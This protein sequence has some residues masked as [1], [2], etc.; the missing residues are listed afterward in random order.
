MG[1]TT[2][3]G[4]FLAGLFAALLIVVAVGV[5][6]R[7]SLGSALLYVTGPAW[8]TADGAM[9]A[10][11]GIQAEI[12]WMQQRLMGESPAARDLTN[13]H[14]MAAEAIARLTAAGVMSS[15]AIAKVKDSLANYDNHKSQLSSDFSQFLAIQQQLEDNAHALVE[16]SETMEEMGDRQ[17]EALSEQ[18]DQAIS[19]NGGLKTRWHAAD[20]GMESQIGF[21]TQLYFLEVLLRTKPPMPL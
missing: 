17:V 4:L 13:A 10:T 5:Y 21:L 19:W 18:P 7:H 9:E 11:I 14:T 20:G 3:L 12:Y 6:A 8:D 1:L 2:R 15:S 16:L